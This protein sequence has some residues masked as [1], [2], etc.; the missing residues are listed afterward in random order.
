MSKTKLTKVQEY[1]V[2]Y[3]HEVIKMTPKTIAKE[4]K[5]SITRIE[6]FLG[7]H[8]KKTK[9]IVTQ[10]TNTDHADVNDTKK[11][12]RNGVSIMTESVSKQG[13]D[14]YKKL[15]NVVSRTARNA[16]FRPRD[17]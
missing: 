1:A 17:N 8:A 3:L 6:Q 14:L 5:I 15:I 10:Q 4:L 11:S 13:D 2:K 7:T 16:I 9:K 12:K